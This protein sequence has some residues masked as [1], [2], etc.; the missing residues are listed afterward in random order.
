MAR[1]LNGGGNGNIYSASREAASIVTMVDD[2]NESVIT[3]RRS[4]R[5]VSREALRNGMKVGEET[6]SRIGTSDVLY[7]S[8]EKMGNFSDVFR[9]F[10]GGSGC[11]YVVISDA[12]IRLWRKSIAP[13]P[14]SNVL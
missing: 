12:G 9:L 3:Q 11:R 4:S 1:G 8:C 13:R 5:M 7:G 2:I 6:E 14:I 10:D